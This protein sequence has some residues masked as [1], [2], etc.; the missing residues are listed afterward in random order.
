MLWFAMELAALLAASLLVG[1]LVG[2][3]LW[4]RLLRATRKGHREQVNVLHTQV[5]SL[6]DEGRRGQQR[7]ASVSAE[8]DSTKLL[9]QSHT[10]ELM[11]T[12]VAFRLLQQ[13]AAS[14]ESDLVEAKRILATS[15][16][17]LDT[18]RQSV[19]SQESQSQERAAELARSSARIAV[20]ERESQERVAALQVTVDE[21]RVQVTEAEAL[22]S[23]TTSQNEAMTSK[24]RHLV[25][26]LDAATER[27]NESEAA[28]A[29]ATLR[30]AKPNS[31]HGKPIDNSP[32]TFTANASAAA[33]STN[34]EIQRDVLAL[35]QAWQ[36][37]S[38]AVSRETQS[39]QRDLVRTQRQL[40][41]AEQTMATMR[42]QFAQDLDRVTQQHSEHLAVE[43]AGRDATLNTMLEQELEARELAF[44]DRLATE[45]AAR[46]TQYAEQLRLAQQETEHRQAQLLTTQLTSQ[47]SQEMA[48]QLAMQDAQHQQRLVD[49][50][51]EFADQLIERELVLEQRAARQI[52][53]RDEAHAEHLAA[54]LRDREAAHLQQVDQLNQSFDHRLTALAN[55]HATAL[56]HW[57][58][59]L[60]QRQEELAHRTEELSHRNDELAQRNNELAQRNDELGQR[61]H[62]LTIRSEELTQRDVAMEQQSAE[63][64]RL[65]SSLA[66]AHALLARQ[67]E[68]LAERAADL[69][70]HK[71]R[72]AEYSQLLALHDE[73]AAQQHD[74]LAQRDI[75]L[76]SLAEEKAQLTEERSQ[77]AGQVNA[78][79]LQLEELRSQANSAA[80]AAAE[81]ARALVE[82]HEQLR[83]ET[84]RVS[85]A[86]EATAAQSLTHQASLEEREELL[87]TAQSELHEFRTVAEQRRVALEETQTELQHARA[88]LVRSS[89]E[90]NGLRRAAEAARSEVEQ[91]QADLDLVRSQ[92]AASQALVM[93][94]HAE[95]DAALAEVETVQADIVMVRA[96][97]NT[98]LNTALDTAG[99]TSQ[100]VQAV[101]AELATMQNELLAVQAELERV[102]YERHL[103]EEAHDRANSLA[104]L[105]HEELQQRDGLLRQ[106]EQDLKQAQRD[107]ANAWQSVEVA[108]A[109]TQRVHERVQSLESA[110]EVA[111]RD[112][113][114]AQV[115]LTLR[116]NELSSGIA[117]RDAQ[118]ELVEAQATQIGADYDR[119]LVAL[120]ALLSDLRTADSLVERSL[121]ELADQQTR[122]TALE[123]NAV[124]W[125]RELEALR[126]LHDRAKERERDEAARQLLLAKSEPVA[127]RG[128]NSKGLPLSSGNLNGVA[129]Q[130]EESSNGQVGQPDNLQRI[131]GI[132]P[133]IAAALYAGGIGSF[134]RLQAASDDQ[135]REALASAGLTFA[136]SLRTWSQQAGF[137]VNGDELGFIEYQAALVAGREVPR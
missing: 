33:P 19:S 91:A 115:Q 10:S 26:A 98:A 20:L 61:T 4:A 103:L 37:R 104:E 81:H 123:S 132:G 113:E 69:A 49:Q 110:F 135:L 96:E 89:G 24:V 39:M 90:L 9:V 16:S 5:A 101:E 79:R 83:L 121:D 93:S 65:I 58:R 46:E 6:A 30:L 87:R 54:Q 102:S 88:D 112:A 41:A 109:E 53:A 18:L 99:A 7:F 42:L 73:D 17:E 68:Q 80:E 122:S 130:A 134:V 50:H 59:E 108:Q 13:N 43:L 117:E 38:G 106:V 56:E 119:A 2:W 70:I 23:Q 63:L 97:M 111:T 35:A 100:Q 77:L 82:Q 8:L 11:R 55:E 15:Q 45:L 86:L 28:A 84:A 31:E 128:R 29:E 126:R 76:A 94:A 21:L 107:A 32:N 12:R 118:V 62:E 57:R 60:T 129:V 48:D 40:R 14:A 1:L 136:P 51:A 47:L 114:E 95:R 125:Q 71:E 27:A 34:P 105:S 44:Q 52:E 78:L 124:G 133:K 116:L 75:E 137:L 66:E 36:Q 92:L 72:Q 3:L 22:V 120:G 25:A 85:G 67:E 127:K 74:K 131:E 64:A